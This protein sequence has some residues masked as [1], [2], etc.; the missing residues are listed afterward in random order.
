MKYLSWI[1]C[2]CNKQIAKSI[3]RKYVTGYS[4]DVYDEN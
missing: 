3:I 2:E 4:A 1:L